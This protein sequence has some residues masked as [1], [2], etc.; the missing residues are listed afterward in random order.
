MNSSPLLQLE[1][2]EVMMNPKIRQNIELH[3]H[4]KLAFAK[5]YLHAN[6]VWLIR[7]KNEKEAF[8]I[9]FIYLLLDSVTNLFGSTC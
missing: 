9:R 1:V 4:L 3:S 7:H 2:E 8:I 6:F 5:T